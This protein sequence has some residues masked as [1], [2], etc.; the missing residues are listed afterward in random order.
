MSGEEVI[1]DGIPG[2]HHLGIFESGDGAQGFELDVF[3][4]A[5]AESIHIDFECVPTFGLKK[6]L[7][8]VF[9]GEADDLVFDGWAIARAAALDAPGEQRGLVQPAAQDIASLCICLS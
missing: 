1:F 2:A 6:D 9:V 7:V 5:R 8:P 4:Q 3:G